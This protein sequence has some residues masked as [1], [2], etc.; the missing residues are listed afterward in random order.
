MM[1]GNVW[2]VEFSR[3]ARKALDRLETDVSLRILDRLEELGGTE[4]PL[5]HKAVRALEGKLKPFFRL[6]VGDYRIIFEL[7]SG[8]KRIGILAIVP[9]GKAYR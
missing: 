3:S 2:R 5:G 1:S 8:G 7:D 4:N 6:R 9:R